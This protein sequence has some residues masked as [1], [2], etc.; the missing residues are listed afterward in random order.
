M[1]ISKENK[2]KYPKNWKQI[3]LNVRALAH[4][5]CEF[6]GLKNGLVG[7]RDKEGKFYTV[8]FIEDQLNQ[9]G[10][11]L[12]ESILSHHIN[13]NGELKKGFTKIVLTVAHLDH[14]PENNNLE[15]LKALCQKCHLNYDKEQHL[16][17]RQKNKFKNQLSLLEVK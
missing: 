12:Y 11:D 2:L 9:K 7:L 4:N 14:N 13:K 8:D 17:T 10:I 15:N 1:P 16:K 3:S 6:C 5:K